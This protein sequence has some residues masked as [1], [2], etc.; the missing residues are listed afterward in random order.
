MKAKKLGKGCSK[1]QPSMGSSLAPKIKIDGLHM[2]MQTACWLDSSFS[3]L[4]FSFFNCP[5]V[6]FLFVIVMD[7]IFLN[8]FEK[9]NN[10]HLL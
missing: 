5:H 4:F 10:K 2:K 6:Y 3:F 9:N 7:S 8:K 1:K